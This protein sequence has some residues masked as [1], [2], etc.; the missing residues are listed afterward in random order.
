MR[1][2][3]S[4]VRSLVRSLARSLGGCALV[5]G[6][7]LVTAAPASAHAD[8]VTSDPSPGA[9]LD[10]SPASV[11]L[12]F[13]EP[14]TVAN[15]AIRVFDADEVRVDEGVVEV[16]DRIAS[17]ALP[18]LDDGAYV[19][20]WRITSDDGHP[21]SGAFTFQVGSGSGPS[22]TSREVT[23]LADRLLADQGGEAIVGVVYGVA[24]WL[25]FVGLALLIGGT[26][27][28]VMWTGARR[29]GA[30][31]R[32]IRIGWATTAVA[33]VVSILVYG[34]YVAGLGLGDAFS[35]SLLGDTLSERQGQVWIARIVL[36]VIAAPLLTLLSSRDRAL[37]EGDDG[38]TSLPP[39]WLPA[40]ALVAVLL[41]ATPGLSGH[42]I[43]GRWSDGAV[44]ADTLHVLAMSVWLGGIVALVATALGS[45]QSP[46]SAT[47]STA[48]LARFSRIALGS[49]AV[50]AATGTFQSIRQLSG[51]DSLRDSEFG[52]ILVVKLVLVAAIV[53]VAAFSREIVLRMSSRSWL[54]NAENRPPGEAPPPE[55]SPDEAATERAGFRRS[56]VFE[57]ALG[58]AV[59][60]AT[61]LLVNAPPGYSAADTAR[62][63]VGVTMNADTVSVDVTVTPAVAGRNDVHVDLFSPAGAPLDVED[64]TVTFALPADDVPPIDVPLRRLG[65]G[66]YFSPGF[67]IPFAGEWEIVANPIVSEFEQPSLEGTVE[68]T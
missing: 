50:L 43:S 51:F 64:V 9:V 59:L 2:S 18:E 62:G 46:G 32:V 15:G 67:D 4:V 48:A 6:A 26:A 53:V 16:S 52:R 24:R 55:L 12:E 30:T 40:A 5:V 35:T 8:L 25:V 63:A 60:A 54:A 14:V 57:V 37:E 13:T 42:A 11:D 21:V 22:A 34:P 39:W 20:T 41:A 3:R 45:P 1:P 31:R 7:V 66:H 49:I 61:A 44:I 29:A 65:P 23:G 68:I 58:L 38:P 36:L 47:R 33:T 19:V 17:L 28:T 56:V 10:A 27:F